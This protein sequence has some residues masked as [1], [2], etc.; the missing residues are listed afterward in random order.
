GRLVV[1]GPLPRAARHA[2]RADRRG[3]GADGRGGRA[4]GGGEP[5]S[6]RLL[7]RHR[8][9]PLQAC[10]RARR[11]AQADL[12]DRPAARAGRARAR[13]RARGRAARGAGHADLRG[14]AVIGRANGVRV[15]ITGLGTCV[16]ERVVSN[17]ELAQYVDT[18]DEW[19]VER[20]GIRE[21]RI[22]A[23]DE[24]LSDIAL[25]AAE[26]ALRD[27]GIEGADVDLLVVATVTPDMMFPTT[28]A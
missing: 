25:P 7:R 12:R 10:R 28:S 19:I 9:L 5:G 3:D 23:E 6:H 20:T 4:R 1:P 15:G 2:G 21:R 16:P 18:S 22:A 24:A 26:A 14:G 11:R 17:D 8:R 27:A 13:D